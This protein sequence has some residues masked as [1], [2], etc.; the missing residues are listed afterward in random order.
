M[1]RD[2][3]ISF[4]VVLSLGAP[5]AEEPERLGTVAG[6]RLAQARLGVPPA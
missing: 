4:L 5:A 3:A 2:R 1:K 6:R